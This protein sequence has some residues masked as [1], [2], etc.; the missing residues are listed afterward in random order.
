MKKVSDPAGPVSLKEAIGLCLK[1]DVYDMM[2]AKNIPAKKS[3][4]KAVLVD[5]LFDA[6]N[7]L[8]AI[9]PYLL[10]L[11]DAEES[12]LRQALMTKDFHF[13]GLDA[14][15]ILETAAYVYWDEDEEVFFVPQEVADLYKKATRR[16]GW[17][18]RHHQR[19]WLFSCVMTA[20]MLYA[21]TPFEVFMELLKKDPKCQI[22]M[23][24]I[25]KE[26]LTLPQDV[27]GIKLVAEPHM[28]LAEA[29]IPFLPD[30]WK[31]QGDKP[32]Y[33]PTYSEIVEGP[34]L[35]I[36]DTDEGD[37]LMDFLAD[38]CG[39]E[40]D[41]AWLMMFNLGMMLSTNTP[42]TAVLTH[43]MNEVPMQRKDFD[44]FFRLFA[45]FNNNTRN[46]QNRGFTP[47]EMKIIAERDKHEFPNTHVWNNDKD[48]APKGGRRSK[49]HAV[50]NKPLPEIETFVPT[51]ADILG[52]A[53]KG[54][55]DA[56]DMGDNDDTP[57]AEAKEK[58]ADTQKKSKKKMA[59]VTALDD[60]KKRKKP[61]K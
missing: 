46:M 50:K 40:E 43:V 29:L 61:K 4:R 25:G 47:N 28:I 60:Y 35:W 9:E 3:E 31:M 24:D 10:I 44:E 16:V 23:E 56:D 53:A 48:D 42:A 36:G 15:P 27:A 55:N 5:R 37:D 6:M 18:N 51:Y 33:I 39:M 57:S 52:M 22:K 58:K 59:S 54:D 49:I 20:C 14:F 1:D 8:T 19:Q 2:K 17:K 41:D 7:S 21:I 38:T 32:F 11:S 12:A 30:I 45:E 13:S 26:L 34:S